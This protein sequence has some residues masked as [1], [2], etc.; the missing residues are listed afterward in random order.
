MGEEVSLEHHAFEVTCQNFMAKGLVSTTQTVERAL[1]AR[2]LLH[3]GTTVTHQELHILKPIKCKV[4]AIL[5]EIVS[6]E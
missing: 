2:S 1:L 4:R 5:H 3:H 6:E